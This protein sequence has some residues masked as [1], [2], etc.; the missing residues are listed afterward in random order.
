[1]MKAVKNCID[2]VGIELQDALR[3]GSLYPARVLGV[4]HKTGLIERNYE[5]SFVVFDN[6]MNVIDVFG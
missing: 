4:D 3:M 6:E 5:A 1:M 2:H